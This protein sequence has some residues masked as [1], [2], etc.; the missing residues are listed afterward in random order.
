MMLFSLQENNPIYMWHGNSNLGPNSA[1]PVQVTY[2]L[3]SLSNFLEIKI[4]VSLSGYISRKMS[5]FSSAPSS[6]FSGCPLRDSPSILSWIDGSY[7]TWC[8]TKSSRYSREGRERVFTNSQF[9]ATLWYKAKHHA[10]NTIS[11]TEICKE[12]YMYNYQHFLAKSIDIICI[13]FGRVPK[14]KKDFQKIT[15]YWDSPRHIILSVKLN[16]KE[17]LLFFCN[18]L[19]N[20]AIKPLLLCLHSYYWFMPSYA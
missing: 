20:I 12:K 1:V 18:L 3:I 6:C 8:N 5:V 7:T 10:L 19:W 4:S 2:W 15:K 14:I 11:L 9:S 13:N 17:C 16:Q